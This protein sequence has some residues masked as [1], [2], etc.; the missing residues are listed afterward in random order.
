MNLFYSDFDKRFLSAL[1]NAPDSLAPRAA[2]RMTDKQVL[3]AMAKVWVAA[4][5]EASGLTDDYVAKLRAEIAMVE[6]D[7]A[8]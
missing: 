6:K 2:K 4:D 1:T 5:G 7:N 3:H 8:A